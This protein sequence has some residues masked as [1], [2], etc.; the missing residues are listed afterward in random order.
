MCAIL[1]KT[2]VRKRKKT[3]AKTG[4]AFWQIIATNRTLDEITCLN[5]LRWTLRLNSS[6]KTVWVFCIFGICQKRIFVLIFKRKFADVSFR[7]FCPENALLNKTKTLRRSNNCKTKHEQAPTKGR[8][9]C[10]KNCQNKRAKLRIVRRQDSEKIRAQR[11]ARRFALHGS[12]SCAK[13]QVFYN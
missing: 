6:K 4:Y 8:L 5:K 12:C 7:N 10:W 2:Q 1:C 9:L 11:Q 3:A 13:A